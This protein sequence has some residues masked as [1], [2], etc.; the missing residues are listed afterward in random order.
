[1]SVICLP[2]T[3]SSAAE[4]RLGVWRL[5]GAVRRPCKRRRPESCCSGS[6]R[7]L[8][9]QATAVLW[10]VGPYFFMSLSL[11]LCVLHLSF[12]M[13]CY[14]LSFLALFPSILSFSHSFLLNQS[15]IALPRCLF[16]NK[17]GLW[18]PWTNLV[19]SRYGSNG[20]AVEAA[21]VSS[22]AGIPMSRRPSFRATKPT[23]LYDPDSADQSG[24]SY[25]FL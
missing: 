15:L 19:V 23:G 10:P 4:T 25:I 1:M 24:E 16:L 9:V 21:D 17:H 5:R 8:S 6:G 11:L 13:P 14:Y 22:P 12:C 18:W 20:D 3:S 2:R 7:R